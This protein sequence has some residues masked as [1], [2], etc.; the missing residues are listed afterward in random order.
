MDLASTRSLSNDFQDIRL[1]SLHAT[2]NPRDEEDP[3][4]HGPYVILQKGIDPDDSTA[5][6]DEFILGRDGRWVTV[7]QFDRLPPEAQ[8][9]RFVYPTAAEAVAVLQSLT[10]RAVVDHGKLPWHT[11]CAHDS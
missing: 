2:A 11:Q 6:V 8:E 4:G 1:C 3:G 10:G 7:G 5:T 9:S